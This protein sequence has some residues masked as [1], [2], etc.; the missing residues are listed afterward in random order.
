MGDV[1]E[2]VAVDSYELERMRR[3][4]AMLRHGSQVLNREEAMALI[5]ELQ[6]VQRRLDELRGGLARLLEDA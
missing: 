2:V 6:D 3:S 5:L 1:G 4:I